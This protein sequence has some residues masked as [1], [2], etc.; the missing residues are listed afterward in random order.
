MDDLLAQ[1]PRTVYDHIRTR[2][3]VLHAGAMLLLP[4]APGERAWGP[5]GGGLEPGE[6]LAEAVARDV[7]EET[8][9]RV[10]MG[11]V[12][13]LQEWV[14]APDRE[15]GHDYDLHVF[16]YAEPIGDTTARPGLA[17]PQGVPLARVP[18]LPLYPPELK[19]LAMV[20]GRGGTREEAALV[21]GR[22]EEP[23]APPRPLTPT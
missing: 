18:G 13:F 16:L 8:G 6:G 10:R 14:S 11:D 3:I 1:P 21:R 2:A 19:H 22:F 9:V 20:L 23:E 15:V 12:A 4:P 7:M 17:A 5:P